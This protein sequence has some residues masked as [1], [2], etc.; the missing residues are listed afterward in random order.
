MFDKKPNP[1]QERTVLVIDNEHTFTRD[2]WFFDRVYYSDDGVEFYPYRDFVNEQK[3][4][5]KRYSCY[6]EY[7]IDGKWHRRTTACGEVR[8]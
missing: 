3:P 5:W 6:S 4:D 8:S 2:G 1:G 7:Y